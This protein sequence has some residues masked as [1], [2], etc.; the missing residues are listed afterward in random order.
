[1]EYLDLPM[2]FDRGLFFRAPMDQHSRD[3]EREADKI[4]LDFL[5]N[6]GYD[7]YEAPKI[8]ENIIKEM[9]L[10]E[11][12][13][14]LSF[15]ASHPAPEERIKNLKKQIEEYKNIKNKKKSLLVEINGFFFF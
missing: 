12:N 5:I 10:G 4:G 1:M 3:N 13:K 14:P 8:W 15:L 7:P 9:E 6:S 2:W 11:V